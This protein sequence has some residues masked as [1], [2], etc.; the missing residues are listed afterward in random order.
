MSKIVDRILTRLFA[1]HLRRLFE[2]AAD[3][4]IDIVVLTRDPDAEVRMMS[5]TEDTEHIVELM[6]QCIYRLTEQTL[7]AAKAQEEANRATKQ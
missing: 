5:S 1:G 2:V 3:L 4:G 7:E 6:T